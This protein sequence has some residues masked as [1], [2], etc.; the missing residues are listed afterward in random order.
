MEK[1][2]LIADFQ[3]Q[4]EYLNPEIA[5]PERS[6]FKQTIL[7]AK[8]LIYDPFKNYKK[9]NRFTQLEKQSFLRLAPIDSCRFNIC[10]CESYPS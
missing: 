7:G 5:Y 4:Y 1:L 2:E 6:A 10:W 3:Y 9:K 8:Y